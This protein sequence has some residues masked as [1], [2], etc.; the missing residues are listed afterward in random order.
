[1]H[2]LARP[3]KI[4]VK[5]R[6]RGV[7]VITCTKRPQYRQRLLQNY[8]RQEHH[9]KE[10]IV[11]L[12]C[13]S[14]EFKVWA[15]GFDNLAGIRVLHTDESLS[16][17]ACFNL[18]V[19]Q[20]RY[21]YIAKFDDDDY[22]APRYLT[23]AVKA[24]IYAGAELVGKSTRFVYFERT[25][26]LALVHPGF[27]FVYVPYVVGATLLIKREVFDKVNFPDLTVGEDSLFQAACLRKGCRISA[28]YCFN[29]VTIRHKDAA[30]HT[31]RIDD[32]E[33]LKL[34]RVVAR[35]SD[36]VPFITR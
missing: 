3:V 22:Y 14:P 8:L 24:S 9:P 33:Y 34:G 23:N 6:T 21:E 18:G 11:V 28:N 4:T 27:E 17:G 29:Y 2:S 7:S 19:S 25:G 35:T 13:S 10:L 16:L 15:R 5:S 31:F 36:F 1:M 32:E 26:T 30:S 20:A 12:H